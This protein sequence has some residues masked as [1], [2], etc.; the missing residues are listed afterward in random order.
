MMR[1]VFAVSGQWATSSKATTIQTDNIRSWLVTTET[2]SVDECYTC[3]DHALTSF[4]L[5]PITLHIQRARYSAEWH[6]LRH[7]I[8]QNTGET[9]ALSTLSQ[10]SATFAENGEIT[11]TTVAL[12]C[13]C[14][15]FRRQSHFSATVAI[16]G[17]L[18]PKSATSRQCGQALRRVAEAVIGADITRTP[19]NMGSHLKMHRTI[20]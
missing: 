17:E 6:R 16:F 9:K 15:R 10:K 8:L 4:N 2:H 11:A 1:L 3:W 18:S 20:G 13:D 5:A 14:C 12:F 7:K 19:R